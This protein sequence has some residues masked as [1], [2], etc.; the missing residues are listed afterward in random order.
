M[1]TK[2]TLKN[3]GFKSMDAG[4]Y[5]IQPGGSGK[6]VGFK[7]AGDQKPGV[8]GVTSSGGSKSFGAKLKTGG[9]GKM[10]TFTATAAQKSGRTGQR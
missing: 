10:Q 3:K 6:M 9:S 1:A 5:K 8:T 4:K 7:A 2:T